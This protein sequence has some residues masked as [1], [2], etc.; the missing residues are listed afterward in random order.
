MKTLNVIAVI[1]LV[2][3]AVFLQQEYFNKS[4]VEVRSY[5]SDDPRCSSP[6]VKEKLKREV[7]GCYG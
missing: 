3:F 1:F 4:E 5:L 6:L 2:M 7:I